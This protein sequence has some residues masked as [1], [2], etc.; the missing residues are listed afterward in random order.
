MITAGFITLSAT[1]AEE[2]VSECERQDWRI[3]RLPR[4]LASKKEFFEG[5]RG[6]FPLDPPLEGALSW[7]ALDDSLWGGLDSLK[8]DRIV[9]VWPDASHMRAY[10]PDEYA[11]ATNVLAELP[12]LL[13][14]SKVTAGP[15]KQLLVLQVM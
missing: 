11:I 12:G 7:D 8:D 6:V 5:V 14:D 1:D 9:I 15:M 3:F 4:F 10:A 2:T 13:S